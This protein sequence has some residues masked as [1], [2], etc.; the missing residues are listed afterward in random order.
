MST[1]LREILN[2]PQGQFSL[3]VAMSVCV[4]VEGVG[5][6]LPP[7]QGLRGLYDCHYPQTFKTS[8]RALSLF[9]MCA[10]NGTDTNP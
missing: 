9:R 2:Q 1:R 3:Q 10:D 4:I 8:L 7:V 6:P 5:D